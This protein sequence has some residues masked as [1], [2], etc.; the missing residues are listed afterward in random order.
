MSALMTEEILPPAED[1][2]GE[3]NLTPIKGAD[4]DDLTESA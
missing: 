4:L 2:G 1:M 3:E